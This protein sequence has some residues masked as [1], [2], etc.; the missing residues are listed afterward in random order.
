M[1]HQLAHAAHV[2]ARIAERDER[3][4]GSLPRE[5]RCDRRAVADRKEGSAR[6]VAVIGPGVEVPIVV[7]ERRAFPVSGEPVP[8]QGQVVG[9]SRI[10]ERDPDAARV[11]P[12]RPG[13]LQRLGPF[14]RPEVAFQLVEILPGL[15]LP[16]DRPAGPDCAPSVGDRLTGRPCAFPVMRGVGNQELAKPSPELPPLDGKLVGPRQQQAHDDSPGGPVIGPA[17]LIEKPAAGQGVLRIEAGEPRHRAQ[18]LDGEMQPLGFGP[19]GVGGRFHG[20]RGCRSEC[21]RCGE[22]SCAGER[23]GGHCLIRAGKGNQ[24]EK[25]TGRTAGRVRPAAR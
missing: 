24:A 13:G 12:L 3:S 21:E 19:V 7:A 6:R 1:L 2:G 11:R 4:V 22:R 5:H 15:A 9:E 10:H 17:S 16:P 25:G 8:E 14:Q 18:P 23:H 20:H